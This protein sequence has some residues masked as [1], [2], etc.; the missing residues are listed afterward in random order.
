M[1]PHT[2]TTTHDPMPRLPAA[3]VLQAVAW[4]IGVCAT[5]FVAMCLIAV[6]MT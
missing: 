3:N 1:S 6:L 5:C 2:C 4:M